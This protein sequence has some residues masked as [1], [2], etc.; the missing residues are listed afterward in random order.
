[1]K[2]NKISKNWVNKQRRDTYVKQSKVDGY[3]ARSAYKL[4]EIDDKF[5]IFK[6]GITV[7]DIGAAPGSWSQ[8]AEKVTKS[9]RLISI[10]LKKM[11]PIGNTVQIQG[12]FTEQIIQDEIKKHTNTNVDVVLSDMAVNTTGIKNIDSIQTGELCKEAMFFAK[13]LLKENGFFISKIFMGGTFNEIVAEGKK[14]FKEVKVFKPK[15]SRK[16]SKES[17]IICKNLR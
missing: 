13:D 7:I 2:K 1:M 5:K 8:Y 11:E 16:D 9:G 12:D 3:R 10:D 14:Y 17:F 4:I 6:G 15:S